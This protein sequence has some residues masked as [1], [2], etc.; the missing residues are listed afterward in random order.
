[1]SSRPHKQCTSL[2]PLFG[3]A[4]LALRLR[5][6]HGGAPSE[7]SLL[8][9]PLSLHPSLTPFIPAL[10]PSSYSHAGAQASPPDRAQ[11]AS[12]RRPPAPPGQGI[13]GLSEVSRPL[14]LSAPLPIF[15]PAALLSCFSI[16][17]SASLKR[18]EGVL[19]P[20]RPLP[21]S[22]VDWSERA[23]D[24]EPA[25][26][27]L[28]S[29]YWGRREGRQQERV[30]RSRLSPRVSLFPSLPLSTSTRCRGGSTVSL[31]ATHVAV[32]ECY[33]FSRGVVAWI[34]D[35]PHHPVSP[36]LWH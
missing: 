34:R 26:L 16:A 19:L 35:R 20:R 31:L 6:S 18:V 15:S 30:E 13:R 23:S 7:A 4:C 14:S 12:S 1:M 29:G 8:A 22:G 28:V 32:I 36:T 11:P 5:P 9:A 10:A 27:C 21:A 3:A 25:P 33:I 17:C 24:A 2:I